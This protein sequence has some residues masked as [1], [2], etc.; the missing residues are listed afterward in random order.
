MI[1]CSRGLVFSCSRV[2]L[3][4]KGWAAVVHKM[5]ELSQGE[6]VAKVGHLWVTWKKNKKKKK[7]NNNNNKGSVPNKQR[8]RV[9]CRC[10]LR[11]F[12]RC[13]PSLW[14][15]HCRQRPHPPICARARKSVG[16]RLGSVRT[17]LLLPVL[18]LGARDSRSATR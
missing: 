7:N 12:R 17:G 15:R 18:C 10:S 5:T 13:S 4:T 6:N 9:C 16:Y 11:C 1:S 2:D 14:R 8:F 3:T